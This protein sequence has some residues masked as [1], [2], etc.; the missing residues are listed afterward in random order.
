MD[1]IELISSKLENITKSK[2]DSNS[3]FKLNKFYR[4]KVYNHLKSK[5]QSEDIGTITFG[6]KFHNKK[7]HQE[8][9]FKQL[10]SNC[11]K[12]N[13]EYVEDYK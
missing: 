13:M 4:D 8:D 2:E 10:I 3:N 11:L 6:N 9:I 7:N 12:E 1:N 5:K